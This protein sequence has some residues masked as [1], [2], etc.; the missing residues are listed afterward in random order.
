MLLM[1]LLFCKQTLQSQ[2]ISINTTNLLNNGDLILKEK[3]VN[4]CYDLG[5]SWYSG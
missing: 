5:T 4:K 2:D 1:F 3:E